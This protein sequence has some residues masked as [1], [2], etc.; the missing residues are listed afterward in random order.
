MKRY[1]YKAEY[2]AI[3]IMLF[4]LYYKIKGSYL[5]FIVTFLVFDV[6]GLGYLFSE[7]VGNLL[8]NLGHTLIFPLILI[9]LYLVAGLNIANNKMLAFSVI[10]LIHIFVDRIMGWGLMPREG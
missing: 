5:L 3:I 7:K 8:Y 2:V 4:I 6:G 10:W 1:I 9:S